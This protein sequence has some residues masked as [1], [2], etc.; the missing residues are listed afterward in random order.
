MRLLDLLPFALIAGAFWLLILRPAKV[1]RTEQAALIASLAPGQRVMTT[2][3]VFGTLTSVG[4][5]TVHLEIAPG[6]VIAMVPQ[7]IGRVVAEGLPAGPA[8]GQ[9][10]DPGPDSQSDPEG[11]ADQSVEEDRG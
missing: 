3:G 4:A 7:A 1:R 10:S 6:V 11:S 8:Q 9:P 2:A 5:E